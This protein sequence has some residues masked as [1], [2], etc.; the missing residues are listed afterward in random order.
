MNVSAAYCDQVSG[1]PLLKADE[2][3]RWLHHRVAMLLAQ[4]RSWEAVLFL[5]KLRTLRGI[6]EALRFWDAHYGRAASSAASMLELAS[7]FLF[8]DS[9]WKLYSD[10]VHLA[11]LCTED[12]LRHAVSE[13]VHHDWRAFETILKAGHDQVEMG[14]V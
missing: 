4:L 12:E 1:A 10:L 7:G 3:E 8:C 14:A 5:T 11:E 13:L 2:A 6:L 9:D